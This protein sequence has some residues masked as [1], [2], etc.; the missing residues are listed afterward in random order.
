MNDFHDISACPPAYLPDDPTDIPAMLKVRFS[1]SLG[2]STHQ[3]PFLKVT[4]FVAGRTL[5]KPL[6]GKPHPWV[7]H[8]IHEVCQQIDGAREYD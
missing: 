4:V 6:I 2:T 3:P 1:A 8:R 7:Q 5:A